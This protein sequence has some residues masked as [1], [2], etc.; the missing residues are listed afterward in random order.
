ML[1]GC[2]FADELVDVL[3]F[4]IGDP[5]LYMLAFTHK[6][7]ETQHPIKSAPRSYDRLEFIGDAV[8][9]LVVAWFLF[10]KYPE[11]PEG[12]L[13]RLRTKLVSGHCLSHISKRLNLHKFVR[14]N[15]KALSNGWQYN[16]RILEDVFEALVAAISLDKGLHIAQDFVLRCMLT[17]VAM[18]DIETED[19]FKDILMRYTQAHG[20]GLPI[21]NAHES[22]EFGKRQYE[23][24]VCVQMK[25]SS[26]TVPTGFGVAYTKKKA[27]QEAAAH[28]LSIIN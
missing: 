4:S 7:A 2:E 13:T 23:V 21:Y 20:V 26:D 19:N 9:N 28:A 17:H 24:T 8:I 27:E 5:S 6:S 14:M 25:N 15:M 18:T 22:F 1:Q 3:G 16:D 12:Y 11:Q 10:L